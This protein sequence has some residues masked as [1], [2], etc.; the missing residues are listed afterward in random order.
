MRGDKKKLLCRCRRVLAGVRYYWLREYRHVL[1]DAEVL[2]FFVLLP[3]AYPILYALIYNPEVVTDIPV[4]VVDDARTALSREIV[5]CFDATP[6]AHIVGYC[7]NLDEARIMM[8]QRE[9]Y[10]ILLFP[11]NFTREIERGEQSS[12]VFYTD[13]SLLLNYKELFMALNNVVLDIESAIRLQK[14]PI[15]LSASITD[16]AANPI[17]Y[18]SVV[19]YNP[20]SGIASFLIPAVLVLILQQSLL[21]GIAMLAGKAHEEGRGWFYRKHYWAQLVGR[22]LCYSSIYLFNTLYLLYFVPSIFGYPQLGAVSDIMIFSL[23]FV[24][25]SVFMAVTLSVMVREREQVY[26]LFVAMSV[27]L[28]FLSGIA[29]PRYAMPEAWRWLSY[30]FPSTWGVE[31]F[32]QLSTMGACFSDVA[33]SYSRLWVL[34]VFYMITA[35]VAVQ[36][37]NRV[38]R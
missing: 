4:V 17:P 8:M 22:M 20:T 33:Q 28:L 29:W 14:I 30:I 6:A 9:C 15:G 18:T 21:L 11:N 34:V 5:R 19:L 13:M 1:R 3:L 7:A 10:A 37:D 2:V 16:I 36:Y 12:I 25:S 38:V 31:G 27:I 35:R 32:V 24:L 26:L 23:P